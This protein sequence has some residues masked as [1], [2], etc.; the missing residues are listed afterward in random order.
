MINL[1]KFNF[2]DV[3]III[4]VVILLIFHQIKCLNIQIIK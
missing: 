1:R 2:I 3:I 4:L